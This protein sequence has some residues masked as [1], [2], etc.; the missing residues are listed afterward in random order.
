MFFRAMKARSHANR[1]STTLDEEGNMLT[2][3]RQ[4]LA[5]A[6]SFFQRSLNENHTVDCES[7]Q[8]DREWILHQVENCLPE[9][10]RI[11]LEGAIIQVEITLTM[12]QMPK[13]RMSR[14]GGLP[15]EFFCIF[16]DLIIHLLSDFYNTACQGVLPY[17]FLL[18]DIVLLSR[19]GD[20]LLIEN[21]RPI[22]LL[23]T[24]YKILP[25]FGKIGFL[26]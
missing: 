10:E 12:K 19:K 21:K 6:T 25:R 3:T 1:I 24:K 11:L 13:G 9:D 15:V 22:T 2:T 16:H 18:G 26:R 7:T 14:P 17:E 8:E 5:R 20:P 23:N 4:I